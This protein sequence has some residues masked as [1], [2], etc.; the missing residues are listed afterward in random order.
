MPNTVYIHKPHPRSNN[1]LHTAL[2]HQGYNSNTPSS[3]TCGNGA[4]S[5]SPL[6]QVQHSCT[7]RQQPF[8]ASSSCVLETH[9]QATRV[10]DLFPLCLHHARLRSDA[11][12][13][14]RWG[15]NNDT[16]A[17]ITPTNLDKAPV[18]MLHRTSYLLSDSC[19][20]RCA[21]LVSSCW[22]S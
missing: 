5:T 11:E 12:R 17:T 18:C 7:K 8:L 10:R 9:Q 22:S 20:V 3:K 14:S 2:K 21:K 19:C 4:V 6:H 13:N 16:T 1:M 15:Q